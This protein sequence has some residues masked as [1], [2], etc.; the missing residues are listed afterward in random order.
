[1]VMGYCWKN[2]N[3]LTDV[4]NS[5][6]LCTSVCVLSSRFKWAEA[7]SLPK[8][9]RCWTFGEARL[10]LQMRGWIQSFTIN[11]PLILLSRH[12][13][14]VL[15]TA[16]LRHSTKKSGC[17]NQNCIGCWWQPVFIGA[18]VNKSN[19]S[20]ETELMAGLSTIHKYTMNAV[21]QW[22]MVYLSLSVV[23]ELVAQ[24]VKWCLEGLRYFISTKM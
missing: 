3:V 20:S 23:G 12:C 8:Q 19:Q 22:L 13:W 14:R 18:V 16:S 10:L 11:S 15:L 21:V 17:T 4:L 5:T 9:W 24:E 6:G 2:N 7:A 1:M